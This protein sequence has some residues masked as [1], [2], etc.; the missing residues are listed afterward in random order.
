[1][2]RLNA[3]RRREAKLQQTIVELGKARNPAMVTTEGS[4][5]N[6]MQVTLPSS[7]RPANQSWEGTGHKA[8]QT[9]G[10]WGQK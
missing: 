4:L 8:R 3:R 2:A 7:V 9:F 6:S 10:R 5:R 1:M